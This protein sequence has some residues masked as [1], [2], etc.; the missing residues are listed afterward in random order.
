MPRLGIIDNETAFVSAILREARSSEIRPFEL[1][2]GSLRPHVMKAKRLDGALISPDSCGP[3]FWSGLERLVEA[4]P[5]LSVLVC[6]RKTDLSS[7]V[8]GLRIGADDWLTKPVAASEVLARVEAAQRPRAPRPCEVEI[9]ERPRGELEFLAGEF[10]GRVGGV[11]LG[12]TAKEFELLSYL[13]HGEGKVLDR[14]TIY[15]RVWGCPMSSGD[16]SVYTYIRRVR[17][18]LRRASPEWDYIHSLPGVGYLFE[19][20]P[21]NR[22]VHTLAVAPPPAVAALTLSSAA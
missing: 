21:A 5:E 3:D 9:P 2:L 7:R 8:R 19:P 16:R 4:L 11:P 6:S 12:L 14:R 17:I 13:V 20:R 1:P 22:S 18:K 10:D 15:R